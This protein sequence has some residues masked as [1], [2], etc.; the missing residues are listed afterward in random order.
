[1]EFIQQL[2]KY[3]EMIPLNT[4]EI[5]ALAILLYGAVMGLKNGFLKELASMTG[6]FIGLYLAWKYYDQI[7]GG[8]IAF[9]GIWI[10]T[11]IALG[12]L[13][14]LATK[15]LGWTL[16]GGL[17]NRVLG[18]IF[19]VTK[20]AVLIVCVAVMTGQVEYLDKYVDRKSVP[21]VTYIEEKWKTLRESL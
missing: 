17:M 12:I 18:C 21:G 20:W 1:M 8:A 5:V 6:F 9:I 15:L 19:G 3:V 13:V 16:V 4:T 2:G 7:G 10:V 11:P 14:S